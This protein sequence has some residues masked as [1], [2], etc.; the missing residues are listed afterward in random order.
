MSY[1]GIH[2]MKKISNLDQDLEGKWLMAGR[3]GQS[4]EENRRDTKRSRKTLKFL[5]DGFF[6]WTAYNTE[7]FEFFGSG[8]GIYFAKNDIYKESIN[9]FSRD[10]SR[11]GATLKFQYTK[12]INDWFHKGLSSKGM[13]IH[14]IWTKRN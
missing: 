5:I 7:T 13:L 12:N 1:S 8:G 10:N 6:Q 11:V 4:G 14:E 9:Y 3:V 2:K